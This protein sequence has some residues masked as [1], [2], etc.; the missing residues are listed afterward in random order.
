MENPI[1]TSWKRN[2]LMVGGMLGAL[3]GLG[4]AYLMVRRAEK[5]DEPL[6]MSSGE[7]IRLG[8]LLL[9]LLRSITELGGG[10]A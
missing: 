1:D 5:R 9:G 7:G 8:L 4:V 6:R 3:T 10:E 2:T